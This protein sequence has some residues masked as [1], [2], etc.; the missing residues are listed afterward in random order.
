MGLLVL[1]R[2]GNILTIR[3]TSELASWWALLSGVRC[4]FIGDEVDFRFCELILQCL[5]TRT[6]AKGV[7]VRK[8]RMCLLMSPY[9]CHCP[10]RWQLSVSVQLPEVVWFLAVS[11]CRSLSYRHSVWRLRESG[12]RHGV[13]RWRIY[14]VN[15]DVEG[16]V[17]AERY[18]L[19]S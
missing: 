5:Y 6:S 3:A 2:A 18:R 1:Y 14:A 10:T 15:F 4:S 17:V 19:S 13:S 9:T 7:T 11:C 12:M 8:R 16:H